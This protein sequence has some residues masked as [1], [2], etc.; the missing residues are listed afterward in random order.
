[1]AVVNHVNIGEL[2]SKERMKAYRKVVAIVIDFW[3][4]HQ[5]LVLAIELEP[6]HTAQFVFGRLCLD[7][8]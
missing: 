2:F 7:I 1:M 5:C 3:E 4:Q 8:Q 6:P